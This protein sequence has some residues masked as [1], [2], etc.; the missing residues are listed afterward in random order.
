M[1]S[2]PTAMNNEVDGYMAMMFGPTWNTSEYGR[3][4]LS[5]TRARTLEPNVKYPKTAMISYINAA[6]PIAVPITRFIL[7]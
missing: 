4:Q 6:D 5:G 7:F 2:C 1:A 3:S